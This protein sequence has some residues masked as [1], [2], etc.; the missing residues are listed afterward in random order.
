[1]NPLMTMLNYTNSNISSVLNLMRGNS[2]PQ[3]IMTQ[4]AN[5]DPRFTKFVKDNK[6]KSPE[7]IAQAYGLD[8][9]QIRRM[10]GK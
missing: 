1:M 3:E 2:N 9:N 5:R 7:Q 8:F 6:G 10:I 4:L